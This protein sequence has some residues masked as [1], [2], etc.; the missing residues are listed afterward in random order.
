MIKI[1][2][3]FFFIST[4]FFLFF[5]I[6][7]YF[8][9]RANIS[10]LRHLVIEFIIMM[11]KTKRNQFY[12]KNFF[13]KEVGKNTNTKVE[14]LA[15]LIPGQLRCWIQS[16]KLIY[17]LAKNHKVFIFTDPE[18]EEITKKINNENIHIFLSNSDK[19]NKKKKFI[20][21]KQLNQWFKL[22]CLINEIY[23]YEKKNNIFFKTFLKIRTDFAYLNQN[24]LVD[25]SRE[26]NEDSLFAKSDLM[27]SGRREFFLP[28]GNFFEASSQVYLN[29]NK[30]FLPICTSQIINSDYDAY[31]FHWLK[32]PKNIIK[33]IDHKYIF[34]AFKIQ[35]NIKNYENK[36]LESNKNFDKIK[37]TNSYTE[38]DEIFST[39][40]M[41]ARYLNM[42]NIACKAH[43]KFTGALIADRHK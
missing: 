19:Y 25:M 17:S 41:F 16:E 38:E 20:I 29:F 32:Y 34:E 9:T 5:K 33:T 31:R 28:L 6:F 35:K 43:N 39:E 42:N 4:S 8:I 23:N 15:I 36:I 18:F 26:L 30:K 10:K 40:E 1:F 12:D 13:N 37:T 22:H 3:K 14:D 21:H 27:Y 11:S 7:L 2:K 24:E